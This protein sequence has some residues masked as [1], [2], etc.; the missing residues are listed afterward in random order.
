MALLQHE[1]GSLS[2]ASDCIGEGRDEGLGLDIYRKMKLEVLSPL[3]D[4]WNQVRTLAIN[5]V[6]LR[7]E[8]IMSWW[9]RA[10]TARDGFRD[11]GP[12][13][14]D[15]LLARPALGNETAADEP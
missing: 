13:L 10:A 6:R 4:N 2:G 12:G 11:A 8:G 5:M 1:L 14:K 7:Y 15:W 9:G 3:V